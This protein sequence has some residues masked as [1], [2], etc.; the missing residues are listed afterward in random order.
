M[1]TNFNYIQPGKNLKKRVMKSLDYMAHRVGAEKKKMER[2][3]FGHGGP[4][5]EEQVR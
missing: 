4:L 2:V 3:M 5:T 1:Y